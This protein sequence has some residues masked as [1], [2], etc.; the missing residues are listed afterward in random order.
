MSTDGQSPATF[1]VVR[2]LGN[3]LPLIHSP[4]QT[5]FYLR[6]LLEN[7][8]L[9]AEVDQLYVLN[10][11]VDPVKQEI[12]CD[13]LKEHHHPYRIIPFDREAW[14]RLPVIERDELID[15]EAQFETK[16]ALLDVRARQDKVRPYIQCLI[17]I[18]DAR[19]VTLQWA[20]ERSDKEWILLLDGSCYLNRHQ[21]QTL[22]QDLQ[23]SSD[24]LLIPQIQLPTWDR[25][26]PQAPPPPPDG[27][28]ALSFEPQLGLRR[29]CGDL[30][31]LKFNEKLVY[32]MGDKAE[33]LRSVTN[34][35]F[36]GDPKHPW[37]KWHDSMAV[38]GI[39]DRPGRECKY[40]M[41]SSL[42]RLPRWE[43]RIPMYP[44]LDP[45]NRVILTKALGY[46]RTQALWRM[47]GRL[48]HADYD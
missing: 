9:P 41:I 19:N 36:Q 31:D 34:R 30:S 3:D 38:L 29:S 27:D 5:E 39:P 15:L 44:Y 23:A 13:L 45:W 7:D 33:L 21:W 20:L 47:I 12:Y 22:Q 28:D 11:I 35:T 43:K 14:N 26:D 8:P 18:N 16:P 42:Y 6:Y 1:C 37:S 25:A 17:N 40:Q 46:L 24:Y 4:Q 32:G 2:I 10:R 48:Q